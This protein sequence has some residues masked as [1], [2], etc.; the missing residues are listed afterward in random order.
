[1][2]SGFRVVYMYLPSLLITSFWELSIMI[3]TV[4][5]STKS[6]FL[7]TI[8]YKLTYLLDL[9]GILKA[10]SKL[11]CG[12]CMYVCACV[13]R[14]RERERD[15]EAGDDEISSRASII[16]SCSSDRWFMGKPHIT[17]SVWKRQAKPL[18]EC[19]SE[20]RGFAF[21]GSQGECIL[22]SPKIPGA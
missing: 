4:V 15:G 11:K 8:S 3:R 17:R 14:E 12:V 6:V 2:P 16:L 21:P 19:P 7:I 5:S 10:T 20:G 13:C 1:M 18:T 22:L 9:G